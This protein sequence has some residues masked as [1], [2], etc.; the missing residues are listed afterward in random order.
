MDQV[1]QV[2]G[3]LLVLAAFAIAQRGIVDP[4]S[5]CTCG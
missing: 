3:S 5:P 1:I 4:K 2:I